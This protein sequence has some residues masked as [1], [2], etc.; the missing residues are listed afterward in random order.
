MT[1]S[2]FVSEGGTGETAGAASGG[3]GGGVRPFPNYG[4]FCEMA[5]ETCFAQY[6]A[7]NSR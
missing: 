2:I 1:D 3:G 6:V 7:E 5:W 4:S